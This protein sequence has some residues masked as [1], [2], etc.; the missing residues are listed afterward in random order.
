MT[1]GFFRAPLIFLIIFSCDKYLDSHTCMCCSGIS[2]GRHCAIS[3]TESTA[4]RPTAHDNG[5]ASRVAVVASSP[6]ELKEKRKTSFLQSTVMTC[7]AVFEIKQKRFYFIRFL[8]DWKTH[9]CKTFLLV[10][11]QSQQVEQTKSLETKPC[12]SYLSKLIQSL[13]STQAKIQWLVVFISFF[14]HISW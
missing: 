7:K 10:H 6:G 1:E 2:V 8:T 12:C 11:V 13:Q 5:V 4:Q 14:V 9:T 3:R